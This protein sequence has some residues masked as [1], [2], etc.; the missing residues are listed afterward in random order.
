[1]LLSRGAKVEGAIETLRCIAFHVP[2]WPTRIQEFC[3]FPFS[4]QVDVH[5]LD[6]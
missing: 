4:G 5:F 3:G 2:I 6:R 1:M